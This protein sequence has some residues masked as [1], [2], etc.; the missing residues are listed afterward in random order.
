M[1]THLFKVLPHYL[2]H[3]GVGI[4]LLETLHALI[5]DE[6]V[7]AGEVTKIASHYYCPFLTQK[8]CI[9]MRHHVSKGLRLTGYY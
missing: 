4:V 9:I 5:G 6:P 3:K 1:K 8:Q 7:N 2:E